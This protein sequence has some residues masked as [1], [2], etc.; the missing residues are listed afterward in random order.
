MNNQ[1]HQKWNSIKQELSR[2]SFI[3]AGIFLFVLFFQPFP[4]DALDFNDRLLYV[5][6]FGIITFFLGI[7]VL[8]VVQIIFPKWLNLSELT[9]IP[10]IIVSICLLVLTGTAYSFYI[11]FVGNTNL[12]LYILFKIFLVCLLPII[13]LGILYKNKSL[14]MI[15]DDLLQQKKAFEAKILEYD[16]NS[17][18][19]MV[20]IESD[21]KK[22]NFKI[23][24]NDIVL[25]KSA[26]NY[27]KI[28]YIKNNVIE[29][30]MIR[31]TLKNV[32]IQLI[33]RLQFIRCHRTSI[34]NVNYVNKLVKNYNGYSLDIMNIDEK[35][36]VSRQYL[37]VIKEVLGE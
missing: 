18:D 24:F 15:I 3:G 17:E 34:V 7:I 28:F 29:M 36:P 11:R 23:Q 22:E 19:D 31:T 16:Q 20:D 21:N 32:E 25:I 5:T 37:F 10:L 13:I 33:S 9:S 1:K 8:A 2:F 26:D 35:V 4:L 30:Q 12:N 27:I 6:G 14:E